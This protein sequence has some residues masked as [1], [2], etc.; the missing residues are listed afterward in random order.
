[1]IDKDSLAGISRTPSSAKAVSKSRDP[2][3]DEYSSLTLAPRYRQNSCEKIF[4]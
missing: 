1:M 3:S 4:F 2:D